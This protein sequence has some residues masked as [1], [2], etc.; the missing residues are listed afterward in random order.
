MNNSIIDEQCTIIRDS[1]AKISIELLKTSFDLFVSELKQIDDIDMI[2]NLIE[3][4]VCSLSVVPYRNKKL[5]DLKLLNHEF[6]F[7]LRDK[8]LIENLRERYIEDKIYPKVLLD[9][10][11]FFMNLSCNINNNNLNEFKYLFF[12]KIL[13]NEI[14]NCLNEISTYG[15][16]LN[17]NLIIRSINY[18]L[19]LFKHFHAYDITKADYLSIS[20]IFYG[21]IQCLCCSYSIDLIK[22]L[23]QSFIQK[24]NDNQI[25][26][27]CSMPY[28]LQWYSDYYHPENIIKILRILLNEFTL[29]MI[30]CHPDTYYQCSSQ[31]AKMIRHL[32][33][34]FVR[35]LKSDYINILCQ[36]FYHDYCKLVLHWS[37]ILSSILSNSFNK[38]NIKL[39]IR[40]I[41]QNLY[42][43]TLHSNV[44][45]FMK[46]VSNLIP[47]LLQMTDIQNDEIQLNV[48]RCLGKIMIETDI[49][50]MANP[51]KIASM[52]IDYINNTMNDFNKTERFTSLLK[53]L[54][55]FV[56]HDQVKIELIKQNALPLLI[57]CVIEIRFDPINVQQIALEILLALAFDNNALEV[58][59]QN[60]IFMNHIQI[61][62]NNSNSTTIS[63][64]RAAERL[65]WKLEKEEKCVNKSILC[66]NKYKYDIMI[67]YSHKDKDLCFQIHEQ[68]IKDGY[69][70]W[71]DKDC[72]RGST[73][74]GIA[75]AIENSHN[76]LICM[77]NMYK[78]S[79]YCQ[80][81]AHYAFERGCRLIPIVLESNY[82]PDGWLGILVSG[83]IYVNFTNQEF[84]LA[85][86]K[87]KNEI[88]H[89]Q[90]QSFNKLSNINESNEITFIN[91]KQDQSNFP[92]DLPE[93]IS[94]WNC[95]DVKL[96]FMKIK[97]DKTILLLCTHMDGHRLLELYE[98]CLI[99]RESMYQSLKFEL[100][101]IYHTL[102]LISDY[103]TF[104]HEI[105]FYVPLTSTNTQA[106][107]SSRLSI[108]FCNVL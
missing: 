37:S 12:H 89:Y 21:V 59:K 23:K 79:V 43:F 97:L 46:T 2:N 67:S 81:E 49:K 73:M 101:E 76:V 10:L 11:I 70:V 65:L 54:I 20:P 19:I 108:T 35:P 7:I 95:D 42:N 92:S 71:I 99:N 48:Y 30:N 83:K 5:A 55:N 38:Y 51:Q 50:T 13:I 75:N 105:K 74:I 69:S 4:M 57:K 72:L 29:W 22:S 100:N 28:Y 33:Y 64:Q 94:E 82:Q 9:V 56:Q 60:E 41:V 27:L 107:Q 104:L 77:S 93:C 62:S 106:T 88:N 17:N 3:E 61:L 1:G 8:I 90:H 16:Y 66:N 98:M 103:L 80:S 25:L 53:S 91:T 85:Y 18:L 15:K 52:Y 6:Y 34:L 47:M 39:N 14:G 58:L 26:F 40:I 24:L 63:L 84:T 86:E 45:N 68:L 31:L 96:F 102:L 87:L 36:D 78:Q 32:T 44:L